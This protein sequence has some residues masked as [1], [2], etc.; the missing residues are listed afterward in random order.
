VRPNVGDLAKAAR[1][2][3]RKRG[4]S[5]KRPG[6]DGAGD[7]RTLPDR[8]PLGAGGE[9]LLADDPKLGRWASRWPTLL[10]RPTSG[11]RG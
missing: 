11:G 7:S 1:I 6:T 4:E 5:S 2:K 8:R 10:A 3:T 9:V